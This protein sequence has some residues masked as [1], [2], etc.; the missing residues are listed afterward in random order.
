MAAGLR[1]LG[2]L[3]ALAVVILAALVLLSLIYVDV[4][5]VDEIAASRRVL[6]DYDPARVPASVADDAMLKAQELFGRRREH[7]EKFA[8]Q[9]VATYLEAS[10]KDIIMVFNSGGWG[11]NYPDSSTGWSSILDGMQAELDEMGYQSVMINYRRTSD[12]F[13]GVLKEL[14]ELVTN[15]PDKTEELVC[16]VDFLTAHLPLS[17]VIVTGESNGTVV[18]DRAAKLLEDNPQVFCIQTG[19][20]FWYQSAALERTLVINHNGVVPDSFSHFQVGEILR[21]SFQSFFGSEEV[22]E[23]TIMTRVLAPGHDYS[24]QYPQVCREITGFLESS[25]GVQE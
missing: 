4:G 6:A 16:R 25:F 20:P 9:L 12:S 3:K 8:G 15:Y 23:G 22:P 17:R 18:A 7:S 10:D 14:G 21:A 11:W 24:W 1:R 5:F 19:T 2:F 13:L